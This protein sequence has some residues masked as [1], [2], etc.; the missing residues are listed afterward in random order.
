[1][2]L[3]ENFVTMAHFNDLVNLYDMDNMDMDDSLDDSSEDEDERDL[4]APKRYIRDGQNPF[5]F[6]TDTEFKRRFRFSKDSVLHGILPR[7]QHEL[8]KVNN[9]GLPIAPVMQLLVCLRFYA[10]ANYQVR[11]GYFTNIVRYNEY[12][13][14][15]QCKHYTIMLKT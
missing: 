10:T 6:Y 11:L 3:I 2:K 5:E 9:R 8:V 7:I 12:L 14:I 13:M 15:K 1:V 4:R